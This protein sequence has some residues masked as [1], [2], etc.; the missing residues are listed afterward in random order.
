MQRINS[1]NLRTKLIVVTAFF[2][3]LFVSLCNSD[4]VECEKFGQNYRRLVRSLDFPISKPVSI[5][6]VYVDLAGQDR[7]SAF[8]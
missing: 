6:M 3:I 4:Y 7:V 1:N 8:W 5:R 2:D